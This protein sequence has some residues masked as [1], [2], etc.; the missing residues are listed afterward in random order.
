MFTRADIRR[1]SIAVAEKD[2]AG[3]IAGLGRSGIV[4]IDKDIPGGTAPASCGPAAAADAEAARRILSNADEF[5]SQAGLPP[6][7]QFDYTP[8]LDDI[9]GLLS[10]DSEQDLHDSGRILRKIKQYAETRNVLL[11]GIESC[12]MRLA[13]LDELERGAIDPVR[14]RGLK[15]ISYI[16]G[17]VRELPEINDRRIFHISMGDHLL[18]LFP[19]ELKSTMDDILKGAG[20]EDLDYITGP[21]SSPEDEAAAFNRRAAELRKRLARIDSFYSGMLPAWREKMAHFAAAYSLLLKIS[22]VESKLTFLKELVVVNGWMDAADTAGLEAML[23]EICGGRFYLSTGS[24]VESRRLGGIVPVLLKNNLLLRP[25]ELLVKMM[26]IPANSE[27]DP[28]P[29]AALAYIITFGVMFGDAGQGL[30]LVLAGLLINRYA[31]RRQGRR[32]NVSDFGSIMAWCGFSAMIFGLLYGSV[33]S[34]EHLIP[35]LLFHPM[36]RMMDLLLMAIMAGAL[37]ISAGLLL[38]IVNGVIAGRYGDAFFGT[39]GAA[40]LAVYGSFVFFALRFIL[41]GRVPD[42]AEVMA[43]L[44]LPLSVFCMRGPLEYVFF[45][46]E[47][48]FHNGLFEYIVETLVEVIEMFSGFLGNTISYIRAGA[49]A[50]SHAG[51]SIAVYTLA[52]MVDPSMSGIAAVTVIITGNIFIILLEGLVCA[53]QSMRLEYYEFFSKFYKGEGTAFSPFSLKLEDVKYGG[54]K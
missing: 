27:V 40:G 46:G 10:G 18:A 24:R 6:G 4:H 41:A 33:F 13:E 8:V 50:L 17:R 20:F 3:L 22:G 51:L 29:A 37:F 35:A 9:P 31:M 36:E 42:S 49:F 23:G 11:R 44:A 34:N 2:Y 28:T 30:V 45:H 1:V 7:D 25:F 38:N 15:Y 43:A 21:G 53:I 12:E 48:L 54:Y 19:N 52:G 47:H 16:Y 39:K 14:L 32:N 26:G 5:F